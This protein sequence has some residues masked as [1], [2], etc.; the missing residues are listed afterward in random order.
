MNTLY[1]LYDGNCGLCRRT[2]DSLKKWDVLH[3]L[4]PVNA[5]QRG[6]LEK[7]GLGRFKDKEVMRD[8][9]AIQGDAVWKGYDAYRAIAARVPL[10][11]PVW[12]LLWI[13]PVTFFGRHIYRHVADGRSCEI[14]RPEPFRSR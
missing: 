13:W 2:M 14:D 1:V 7:H 10:L 4:T 11:W 5:C 6:E 12:P 3:R 8:M 9:H